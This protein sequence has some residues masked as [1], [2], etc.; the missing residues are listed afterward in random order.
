MTDIALSFRNADGAMRADLTHCLD[1]M[2]GTPF[3]KRYKQ[4]TWDALRISG[5]S[6]ILDV[7]CGVGFDVIALARR[8]PHADVYGLDPSQGFLGLA[9][10][11]AL[12]LPN[13]RFIGG[14][15]RHLPFADGQFDGVRIDR[16]LQHISAPLQA[17]REMVRVTRK[18]G[19][20]VVAEPDW[21]TFFVY[22]GNLAAGAKIAGLWE[23]SFANPYI[24]REIG[25][26]LQACGVESLRCSAHALAV[27]SLEAANVIFDLTRVTENCVEAN[28]LALDEAED[29]R[30]AAKTAARNGA[31]LACLNI[32]LWDGSIPR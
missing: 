14:D 17:L 7:A 29:W 30:A 24:G 10:E 12:G 4:E 22:N 2:N 20:I 31:F 16:S 5:N 1:F 19:R 32:M 9:R 26:L 13:A 27:S 25:A 11:R 18:G 8:F 6:R 15:S 3:F 21:G 28:V 23:Q